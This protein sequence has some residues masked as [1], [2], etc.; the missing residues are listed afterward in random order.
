ML[1]VP[2]NLCII[3]SI[4]V[5]SN[6]DVCG[7]VRVEEFKP[8]KAQAIKLLREVLGFH[9]FDKI[10]IIADPYVNFAINLHLLDY[11]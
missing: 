9:C 4:I 6:V 10:V 3:N 2:E 11:L 5:T 1:R 8:L 7:P